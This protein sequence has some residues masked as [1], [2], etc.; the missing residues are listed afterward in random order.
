MG[1]SEVKAAI[2]EK[3]QSE[4]ED[5]LETGKS[6]AQKIISEAQEQI[7]KKKRE[8]SAKT[9]EILAT[10]ARKELATAHFARKAILL[11]QKRK[12][13]DAVCE[14]VRQRLSAMP[15]QERQALLKELSASAS[16]QL[17]VQ[18]VQCNAMDTE[19][20]GKLFPG[21]SVAAA[22]ISGGF[23]AEN[24]EHTMRLDFT[25]ETMLSTVKERHLAELNQ[26]LFI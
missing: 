22:D 19:E 15:M 24:A 18:R 6:E 13:I 7:N 21:A 11:E 9:E 12:A 1:L 25:Y 8:H 17:R 2:N 3:T 4:V 23:I 26:L 16:S 14:A 20:L 5:L 10:L